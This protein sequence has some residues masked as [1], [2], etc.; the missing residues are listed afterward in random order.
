MKIGEFMV[1]CLLCF[2]VVGCSETTQTEIR[3]AGDAV[4][5]DMQDAGDEIGVGAR[6]AG[7]TLERPG[8]GC[9]LVVRRDDLERNLELREDRA[10]L[11]RRGREDQRWR[12]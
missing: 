8:A 3:E 2:A 4:A 7:G 9:L 6:L 5:T 1:A 11:R 10:A 12:G